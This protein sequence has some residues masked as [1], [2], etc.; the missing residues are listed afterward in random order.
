MSSN[1]DLLLINASPRP[2]GTS[3]M[4]LERIRN[5]IGGQLVH[6]YKEDL[7]ELAGLMAKSLR[8][9]IS[10]PCYINSFPGRVTELLEEAAMIN[11]L[12]S[13]KLYGIINGGMPYIHTHVSGLEHLQLFCQATD[14]TW[15]GGFVLGGGAMLDGAQLEKHLRARRI[16]PAFDQF[17]DHIAKGTA[18]SDELYLNSQTGFSPI[19]TH[20]LA[21]LLSWRVKRSLKKQGITLQRKNKA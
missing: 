3:A 15:Q 13:P 18:S 5:R 9:V 11:P 19:M 4:L 10:G 6:L 14:Y 21:R 12:F 17:V 1:I 20:V 2:K 8:I 7:G 16:V